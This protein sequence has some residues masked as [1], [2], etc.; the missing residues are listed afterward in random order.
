[1]SEPPQPSGE[2]GDLFDD[3]RSFLAEQAG[4]GIYDDIRAAFQGARGFI[5]RELRSMDEYGRMIRTLERLIEDEF[6][7]EFDPKLRNRLAET[8]YTYG[9]AHYSLLQQPGEADSG[10]AAEGETEDEDV[11]RPLVIYDLWFPQDIALEHADDGFYLHLSDGRIDLSLY[12]GEEPNERGALVDLVD[13]W[14]YAA[15]NTPPGERVTSGERI[16]PVLTVELDYSGSEMVDADDHVDILFLDHNG[17]P[18]VR[19]HARST[20]L[21]SII[22]ELQTIDQGD[23]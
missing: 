19:M 16:T 15:T 9:L 6:P 11:N 4:D 21:R 23:D 20:D 2:E 17:E 8:L 1:M 18:I 7:R 14:G 22:D 12:L 3:I 13:H 10:E 5:N